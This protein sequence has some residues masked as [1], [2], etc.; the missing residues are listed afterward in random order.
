MNHYNISQ[1]LR[2]VYFN[3]LKHCYITLYTPKQSSDRHNGIQ[4]H[5]NQIHFQN[6]FIIY[7]WIPNYFVQ[8]SVSENIYLFKDFPLLSVYNLFQ[9]KNIFLQLER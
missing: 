2:S 6:T 1:T 9:H 7:F 8:L 5:M 4:T 3:N